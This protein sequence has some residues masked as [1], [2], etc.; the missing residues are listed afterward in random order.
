MSKKIYSLIPKRKI[1]RCFSRRD[2]FF[3]KLL[4]KSF[5]SSVTLKLENK[6][7][8]HLFLKN[9]SISDVSKMITVLKRVPKS[10]RISSSPI[11]MKK[12]KAEAKKEDKTVNTIHTLPFYSP[13]S[14]Y[15]SYEMFQLNKCHR[16][17]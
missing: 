12:E 10:L 16:Y 3:R 17:R 8:V 1:I 4:Y 9:L 5:F 2:N 13:L 14:S 11:L 15:L 7:I 6:E